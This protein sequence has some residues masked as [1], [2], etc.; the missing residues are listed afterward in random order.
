[1]AAQVCRQMFTASLCNDQDKTSAEREKES[2]SNLTKMY[3]QTLYAEK[4]RSP[5]KDMRR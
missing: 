4:F 5:T 2:D 3:T 1:M